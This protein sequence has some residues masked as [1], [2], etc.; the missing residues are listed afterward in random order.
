MLP[1][2][3]LLLPATAEARPELSLQD[4]NVLVR[5][6][7]I[8]YPAGLGHLQALGA[9]RVRMMLSWERSE[10]TP[11]QYDFAEAQAA[12]ERLRQAGPQV[13]VVLTGP[14]PAWHTGNHRPGVVRPNPQ[15]YGAWAAAAARTLGAQ[16]DRWAV[17][18]EPN[19][20]SLLRPQS[21]APRLYRAL[22][23]AAE[24]ALRANDPG[25][26]VLLGELAPAYKQTRRGA[27]T[28][29]MAFLRAMLRGSGRL[30]ADGVAIH[31]YSFPRS[32]VRPPRGRD[33][34]TMSRLSRLQRWVRRSWQQGRLGTPVG[35]IPG[36]HVTEWAAL[37]QGRY[38]VSPQRQAA[39]AR[40]A[41]HMA[42]QA[43]V[44]SFSWYQL[45]DPPDPLRWSSGLLDAAGQPKPAYAV[46]RD[47]GQRSDC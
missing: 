21:S 41:L 26:Q 39:Y 1:L 5:G 20:P 17:W 31:P 28:P 25:A 27:S 33:D 36:I 35:E 40:L 37:T 7:G 12:V 44:V 47:W 19:W 24:P 23:R 15:A 10:I 13:T 46:L 42:C 2:L 34:V 3:L 32:P 45:Q 18:N 4:E 8:G 14:V 38:Q 6:E 30:Q 16:V 29:P 22:Y 9:Q 11:G 43:G